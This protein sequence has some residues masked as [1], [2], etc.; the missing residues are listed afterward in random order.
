M[1]DCIICIF[2]EQ[3]NRIEKLVVVLY[4]SILY[5]IVC[6]GENIVLIDR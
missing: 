5:F 6:I 4:V 1:Q 2:A 3:Q